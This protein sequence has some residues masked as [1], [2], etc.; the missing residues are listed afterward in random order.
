MWKRKSV[1]LCMSKIFDSEPVCVIFSQEW[2]HWITDN[3]LISSKTLGVSPRGR[4][5]RTAPSTIGN[6]AMNLALD[7][8]DAYGI[9]YLNPAFDDNGATDRTGSANPGS[10]IYTFC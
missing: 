1:T 2:I 5:N 4:D 6:A 8:E 3:M 10:Q 9:G 7:A